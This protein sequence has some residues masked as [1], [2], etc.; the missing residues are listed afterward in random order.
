MRRSSLR[1]YFD[2][3]MMKYQYLSTPVLRNIKKYKK[4]CI[5]RSEAKTFKYDVFKIEKIYLFVKEKK[6]FTYIH[7]F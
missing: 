1:S 6:R 4:G 2:V 5:I 7:W 3:L